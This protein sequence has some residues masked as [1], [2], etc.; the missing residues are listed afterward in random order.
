MT[1]Q[2]P[3]VVPGRMPYQRR[4]AVQKFC[5]CREAVQS[6]FP[7][8]LLTAGIGALAFAARKATGLVSLSPLILAIAA[9]MAFHNLIGTPAR[10]KAGVS[11]SLKRVMRFAIILLGL[12]LTFDQV[13][14]VG[15]PGVAVI[16]VTLVATFGVTKLLARFIGV[17]P[18]LAELIGAGTAICG[19][20]AVIAANTV[21]RAS[22]ADAAY[23]AA[24]V[25]VFGSLSMVLYPAL[26]N[27]IGLAPHAYGLWVGASIHEVAQV[28]AAAF[29][30]GQEAGEFGTIA[31][32][33]RVMMLAPLVIVLA[34]TAR[35]AARH[36]DAAQ[37]GKAPMPWFVLG[38]IALIALNSFDLIPAAPKPFL[39]QATSFLLAMALAAL[40]LETDIA[41][42]REKGLRPLLLGA[43]AWVFISTL[44]LGL[45]VLVGAA[46]A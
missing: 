3:S 13:G 42:L 38:F 2:I 24:C 19:A 27:A 1:D 17:D 5:I 33:S 10:A 14:A 30:G 32:L 35:C 45:V 6:I 9:G 37:R 11:F 21:T 15:G 18:K 43:A 8:V 26:D 46:A 41:K 28:I 23:A 31:K 12:Q 22:D 36:G 4:S 7:G 29:Q 16:A 25:T 39:V 34:K 20:S 40:G 44:S